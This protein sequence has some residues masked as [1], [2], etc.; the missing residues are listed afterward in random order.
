MQRVPSRPIEAPAS[1]FVVF[2]AEPDE[3]VFGGWRNVLVAVW[4]T[5]ATGAKVERLE[6]SIAL[7]ATRT[8]GI[9]S[10]VHVIVGGA[11]LPTPEARAGFASLIKRN[12][13]DVACVATVVCGEG[14]WASA[15]RS[16]TLGIQ[17]VA[18]GSIESR[19]FGTVDAA[20]TWLAPIHAIKTGVRLDVGELQAVL[21]AAPNAAP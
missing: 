17:Q 11:E 21:R 5:Q 2:D 6:K 10:N 8:P 4:K 14:F 16:A 3:L 18:G 7:M 20:A 1:P 15:L 9:R 19:M 13:N 12:K